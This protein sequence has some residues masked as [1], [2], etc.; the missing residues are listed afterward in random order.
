M[1][2]PS[3][4]PPMV[5]FHLT[6]YRCSRCNR[7]VQMARQRRFCALGFWSGYRDTVLLFF[8]MSAPEQ[9]WLKYVHVRAASSY[10]GVLR[11]PF[12]PQ[13]GAAY[14]SHLASVKARE[15]ERMRAKLEAKLLL[16]ADDAKRRWE[17][18][19][20]VARQAS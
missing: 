6:K 18:V 5:N 16:N 20:L 1:H 11:S 7:R 13:D 3:Y 19:V 9:A 2:P 8:W 15:L 10:I 4:Q 17:R 12:F 14:L